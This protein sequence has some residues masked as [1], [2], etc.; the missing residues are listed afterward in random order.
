MKVNDIIKEN[1]D[2][3]HRRE[4]AK[5][6]F[7]GKRAAG[8]ILYSRKTGRFCLAH[9]SSAVQ[10]PDTWGMWGGAMDSGETPEEA[11]YREL[12][13]ETG[14]TG[15]AEFDLLWTFEHSSG[16][17]YYNFL[18]VVEREFRPRMDWETQGFRW[19]NIDDPADWPSPL[20]PGVKTLLSRSDVITKL[21]QLR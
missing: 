1:D 5:T 14:Y 18:A 2:A 4:L 8:S 16:F 3:E 19:F 12:V 9:R 17:R 13:E 11:A 20:H 15:S 6:G 7:W 21:R 10:E